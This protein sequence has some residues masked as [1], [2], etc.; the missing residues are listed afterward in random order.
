MKHVGDR[1]RL[2]MCG[3][4][5]RTVNT[6]DRWGF[7]QLDADPSHVHLIPDAGA[8]AYGIR[9][10]CGHYTLYVNP[11]NLPVGL[12]EGVRMPWAEQKSWARE[13]GPV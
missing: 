11:E 3:G 13:K 4:C 12:P 9:C 7:P 2:M 6:R 8:P 5:G 1:Y 10:K